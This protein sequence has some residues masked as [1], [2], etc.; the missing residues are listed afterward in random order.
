MI[1]K[2]LEFKAR[3]DARG[4]LVALEGASIVPFGI[5]RVYYI[6]GTK[7]GV[8]RGFHAHKNLQQ[9]AVAVTG[10]CEMVFDDGRDQASVYLDRPTLGVLIEPGVWHFIRNFSEDCV[11]MV[12]ANEIYDESDYIRV[13][14]DFIRWKYY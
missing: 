7:P 13:Y 8:E 4:S 14:K 12:L 2:V 11:L 9:M 6:Y 10:S 1:P 5:K 3:G